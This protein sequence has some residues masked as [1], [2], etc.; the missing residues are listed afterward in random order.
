M[1]TKNSGSP[2]GRTSGGNKLKMPLKIPKADEVD[3]KGNKVGLLV[4]S[5]TEARRRLQEMGCDPLESTADIMMGKELCGDHP[6]LKELLNKLDRFQK[7]FRDA[8]MIVEAK[9]VDTTIASA[10]N[11][12]GNSETD[13][14]LRASS[15]VQ[16]LN[17]AYPKLRAMDVKVNAAPESTEEMSDDELIKFL[18]GEQNDSESRH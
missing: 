13:K 6:Y 3:D 1:G 12:M 8:G 5:T 16:L 18:R 2:R 14:A 15:A 9:I 11:M 10:K 4:N 7:A 17:F